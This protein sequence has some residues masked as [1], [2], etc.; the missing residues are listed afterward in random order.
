LADPDPRVAGKGIALLRQKG[1]T[2]EGPVERALCERLNRGFVTVRTKG[3]PWITITGARTLEG[4]IA[5]PDGS[6][7]KI[8]GIEQ[9]T[10]SHTYS[11]GQLDAIL[12]GVQT[13]IHDDPQLT[14]RHGT[15]AEGK[16]KIL[17]T[18]IDHSQPWRIVLDPHL[19][20][21]LTA[22]LVT[23]ALRF[24]TIVIAAD[25]H[26][27][28]A[29]KTDLQSRGIRVIEVPFADGRFA[30]DILWQ[31]L[32]A[33]DGDFHGLTSILVEGGARTWEMFWEEGVVDEE[34]RMVGRPR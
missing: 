21:P 1:V 18:K 23:D 15:L 2:V 9:D 34:V 19:R 29:V 26:G 8:T 13:V 30:W 3:R 32:L 20:I 17:N 12:V 10:W 14:I 5:K 33:S 25:G 28:D 7:L 31:K 4:A 22:K 6:P 11:R 27:Q 24:Q 16:K